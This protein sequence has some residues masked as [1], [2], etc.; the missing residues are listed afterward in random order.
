MAKTLAPLNLVPTLVYPTAPN[1]LRS[2]DVPGYAPSDDEAGGEGEIDSW[3]WFKKDEA[4]GTYRFLKEGM[5]RLAESITEAVAV[6]GVDGEQGAGEEE[7]EVV[8]QEEDAVIDGV[9]GFSQGG[10]MAALLASAMETSEGRNKS[11]E[12]ADAEQQEWVRQVREANKGRPL[13]FAVIYS[14]FFA[15]PG[16]LAWLYEPKVQT[17]T[18]HFIGSLDTVVEE[19]RCQGL[20]DRCEGG[21]VVIHPGGHYVPVNKEWVMPLVGFIR[22]CLAGGK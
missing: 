3:A 9:I 6:K 22:N 20:I 15:P 17:P 7:G 16:E 5:E 4:N 21:L 11:L 12:S 1:R 18:L 10:C 13:K 19:S 2:S 8:R 14:G